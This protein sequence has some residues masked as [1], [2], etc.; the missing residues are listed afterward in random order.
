M[1]PLFVCILKYVLNIIHVLWVTRIK[2]WN[3]FWMKRKITKEFY[4]FFENSLMEIS[5]SYIIQYYNT[6]IGQLNWLNAC[7]YIY[8]W[9]YWLLWHTTRHSKMQYWKRILFQKDPWLRR[10]L[11]MQWGKKLGFKI[12]DL[13]K[14][15]ILDVITA[16]T[17]LWF[18]FS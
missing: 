13:S 5:I 14:E 3:I 6:Y 8:H 2:L 11:S 16:F 7:V 18:L 9:F 12:I 15:L 17:K 4:I 10:A 1:I